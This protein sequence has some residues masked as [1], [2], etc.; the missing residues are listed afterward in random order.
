MP[1]AGRTPPDGA[2]IGYYRAE[3]AARDVD[4]DAEVRRAVAAHMLDLITRRLVVHRLET[5]LSGAA[6]R[7][8]LEVLAR[9]LRRLA[10]EIDPPGPDG[11]ELAA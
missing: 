9:E 3:L 4:V 11:E 2:T 7:A 8:N 6:R 1:D 10:D 5:A